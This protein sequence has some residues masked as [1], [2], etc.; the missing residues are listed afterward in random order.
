MIYLRI[1]TQLSTLSTQLQ[2]APAVLKAQKT[3]R[4]QT[5]MKNFSIHKAVEMVPLW[6][7]LG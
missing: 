2:A 5:V 7:V 6:S 4:M 1:D 3:S